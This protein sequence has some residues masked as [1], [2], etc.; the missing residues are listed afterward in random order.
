MTAKIYLFSYQPAK[1]GWTDHCVNSHLDSL[2][3]IKH[4]HDRIYLIKTDDDIDLLVT[5]KTVSFFKKVKSSK[6]MRRKKVE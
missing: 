2:Y 6:H 1:P 5:A 4:V 3:D